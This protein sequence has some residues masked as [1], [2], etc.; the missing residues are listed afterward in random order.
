MA[1]SE[2]GETPQE[3]N[4]FELLSKDEGEETKEEVTPTP[5]VELETESEEI[6]ASTPEMEDGDSEE[7]DLDEEVVEEHEEADEP[8][9]RVKVQGEDIDVPLTEL[10][11]GYSRTSDYTRK[12]QA[13]AEQR[14]QVQ[15]QAQSL[16]DLQTQVDDWQR[17][18]EAVEEIGGVDPTPEYWEDLQKTDPMQFLIERDLWRESQR[19]RDEFAR[20]SQELQ[21]QMTRQ[22]QMQAKIELD[23][24]KER[25]AAMIPEWSDADRATSEKA[26]I[27]QF[28][29]TAGFS[30]DEVDNLYDARAV[31]ILRKAMLYDRLQEKRAN[32]QVTPSR[33]V[34]SKTRPVGAVGRKHSELTKA[35]QRLAKTGK[36]SDAQNAFAQLLQK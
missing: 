5:D 6:E 7:T 36:V 17:S 24:Q 14:R 3:Q 11:Q 4:F 20:K 18:R 2:S 32:L 26:A 8:T 23:N 33:S 16:G 12:Q 29:M 21:S 30:E 9:F 10:L 31:N 35:K 1:D 19:Q 15:E 22:Q 34:S 28:G 13:L 25:L 27:R